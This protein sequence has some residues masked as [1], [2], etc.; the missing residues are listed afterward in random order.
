MKNYKKDILTIS[1][2]LSLLRLF[3]AIPIWLLMNNF[4]DNFSRFVL[5]ALC[6]V[7]AL[8][9]ILDGY[10]AR[11]RNEITEAG[12]I[13]DP[14]ADKV[15]I[16]LII[17]KLYLMGVINLY[18]FIMIIGRDLIIFIGGIYVSRKLKRILPS[19]VLGKITVIVISFV[20]ILILFNVN[21]SGLLFSAFYY[22]SIFLIFVS[23]YGYLIRA[24]EFLKKKNGTI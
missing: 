15:L 24:K 4:T 23:L 1:N 2:M 12:K 14:L 17:I 7:A 18:Y 9:D 22:L 19:N 5:I 21:H 13:I 20:I 6:L 3:L 10:F 11:K 8:T 16:G